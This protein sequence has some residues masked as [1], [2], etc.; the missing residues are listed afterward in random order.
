MAEVSAPTTSAPPLVVFGRQ[1]EA[2]ER[3]A[4]S[5]RAVMTSEGGRVLMGE[6]L[7]QSRG[8]QTVLEKLKR[9]QTA[10]T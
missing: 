10:G 8:L 7:R 9:Q 1:A 3:Y 4:L 6:L 2:M 5:Q